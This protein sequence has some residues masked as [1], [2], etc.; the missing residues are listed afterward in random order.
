MSADR[1]AQR[2]QDG[3]AAHQRMALAEAEHAYREVLGDSPS[4]AAALRLLGLI[5]LER[6]KLRAVWSLLRRS[7]EANSHLA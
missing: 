2:F 7:V 5:Y 1:I 6:G 3:L 4:H